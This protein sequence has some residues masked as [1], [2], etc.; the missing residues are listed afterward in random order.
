[1]SKIEADKNLEEKL[2]EDPSLNSEPEVVKVED[3]IATDGKEG[4]KNV[5]SRLR[6]KIKKKK[7]YK[8]N[9]HCFLLY[10]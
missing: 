2:P 8:N 3:E 7:G 5:F 10:K 9:I 6:E 4:K 1:M